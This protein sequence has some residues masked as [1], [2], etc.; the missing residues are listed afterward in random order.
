[1]IIP[2]VFEY[3]DYF[4]LLK[5]IYKVNK[6]KNSDFSYELLAQ[7]LSLSK[8][9]VYD[10]IKIRKRVS[11]KKF[12]K[13]INGLQLNELEIEYLL[14]LY[15][16]ESSDED[17]ST[18]FKNRHCKKFNANE[19]NKEYE[20]YINNPICF[21]VIAILRVSKELPSLEKMAQMLSPQEN[22]SSSAVSDIYKGL[23]N[24]GILKI[25]QNGT[26]T[27]SSERF[28]TF[29]NKIEETETFFAVFDKYTQNF[30]E[31]RK[32]LD[33]NDLKQLGPYSIDGLFINL[34]KEKAREL[35]DELLFLRNRILDER[36]TSSQEEIT[37]VYQV[38]I[39][40]F[41]VLF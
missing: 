22:I 34:T 12:Y 33:S 31:H 25:H 36:V 8:T 18:Y 30:L 13:I 40:M 5:D 23:E 1:M 35:S 41:P 38:D 16:K 29:G 39:R 26:F 4:E 24:N 6:E 2:N 32:S 37:K 15:L 14:S 11:F 20:S 21:L 10:A 7:K 3:S 17:L 27:L 19:V 28:F 9:L